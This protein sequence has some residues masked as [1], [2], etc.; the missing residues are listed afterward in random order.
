[1]TLDL[2]PRC[3]LTG[4]EREALRIGEVARRAGVTIDTVRYYERRRLLMRA[5]RSNGGFRLFTPG[6]VERILFIKQAQEMGFSLDE[7]RDLL[8]NGGGRAECQRVHDL[9]QSKLSELDERMER[10]KSFRRT[11]SRHLAAC[12]EELQAHGAEASCPVVVTIKRERQPTKQTT[13]ERSR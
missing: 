1:L 11:L 3:K 7:I 4:M 2:A 10:M 12:E 6:T 8:E 5:Q 9:L 13:K